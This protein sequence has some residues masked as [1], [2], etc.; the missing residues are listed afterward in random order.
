MAGILLSLLMNLLGTG[1]AEGR[2]RTLFGS[3]KQ[4][5]SRAGHKNTWLLSS[6][7][8]QLSVDGADIFDMD[9]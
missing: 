9:A 1:F 5:D 4:A 7:D 3:R 8:S 6:P 2:H